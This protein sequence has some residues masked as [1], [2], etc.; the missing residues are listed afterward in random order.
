MQMAMRINVTMTPTRTPRT[1]VICTRTARDGATIQ[2][3]CRVRRKERKRILLKYFV[4]ISLK[5][6][7]DFHVA[8]SITEGGGETLLGIIKIFNPF[9]NIIKQKS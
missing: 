9:Q 8:G 3:V 5:N 1:G 2:D 7:K 6:E 4:D